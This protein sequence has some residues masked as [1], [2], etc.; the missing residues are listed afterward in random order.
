MSKVS[1]L[2][3]GSLPPM[4]DQLVGVSKGQVPL[5]QL[6]TLGR[7][8]PAPELRVRL[9]V[10][11]SHICFSLCPVPLPSLAV[12]LR[13]FSLKPPVCRS[14]SLSIS[15][16]SDLQPLGPPG[17]SSAPLPH[18]L[19]F[20]LFLIS[21]QLSVLLFITWQCL[22]P[23]CCFHSCPATAGLPNTV[24]TRSQWALKMRLV[25]IEVSCKCKI[26]TAF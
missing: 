11:A 10:T 13:V 19:V 4:A 8:V 18:I 14:H 15:R 16:E 23:A 3:G 2:P 22:L 24:T 7:A 6:G 1:P 20:F 9:A 17:L 26:H 21:A 25:R 5:P 12:V